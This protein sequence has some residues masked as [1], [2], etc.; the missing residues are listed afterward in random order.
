MLKNL[1]FLRIHQQTSIKLKQEW[2]Q[3]NVANY[4]KR[5][6]LALKQNLLPLAKNT[7]K[8]KH[9]SSESGMRGDLHEG[10]FIIV[11]SHLL[12]ESVLYVQKNLAALTVFLD[13]DVQRVAIRHPPVPRHETRWQC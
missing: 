4:G 1:H 7:N 10:Q 9:E 13:E 8:T 6:V 2:G 12:H 3:V 11:W 5:W